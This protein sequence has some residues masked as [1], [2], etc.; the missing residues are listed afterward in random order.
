MPPAH[1]MPDERARPS[2]R[3]RR[4]T[5]TGVQVLGILNV[6]P[7]SF[8]DGGRFSATDVAVARGIELRDQGAD[9]VD[10]GGESTRPGA[11]RVPAEEE[12]RRVIPVVSKLVE[13]GVRVS[14]DTMN[15][16]TAMAAADAGASIIND[17][18]GGLADPDMY[19]V[20]A[21]M[22]LIYIAMHWRGSPPHGRSILADR[23]EPAAWAHARGSGDMA[24]YEDVV[25]DVRDEL[26]ARV[27]EMLVWGIKP[28]RIIL[29]PGIGFAKT[30]E[31]NWKL[32]G[33]LPE[34][35]SLGYPVLVGTSR[36]RF[37]GSFLPDDAAP[38]QRDDATAITTALAAA[39]GAWGVRVH[40]VPSTRLALAIAAAWQNG[41]TP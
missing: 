6:T 33:H 21:Q 23:P 40:D 16:A 36:K 1:A 14:V 17:V 31:H 34:L 39:S 5:P 22:E 32:L 8:S 9:Y 15:S 26:K 11:Q 35:A 30:A 3:S 37:L 18:S 25:A 28:D 13:A 29:D 19:R 41:K 4:R 2:R 12:Q 7:D 20:V 10:V 24:T 38:D 27:A